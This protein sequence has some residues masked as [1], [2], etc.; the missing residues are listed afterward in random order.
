MGSPALHGILLGMA[1]AL[2]LPSSAFAQAPSGSN[3]PNRCRGFEQ[4]TVSGAESELHVVC[5]QAGTTL[6][7][8]DGFEIADL[9]ALRS[10]V[11]VTTLHGSKRAWLLMQEDE[12]L[13]AVEEITGT[14]ARAMGRGPQRKID[15]LDLDLGRGA[16]GLLTAALKPGAQRPE[17]SSAPSRADIDLA[18]LVARSR[19]VRGA[20]AV[21]GK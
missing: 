19:Q 16:A 1:V 6:G 5:G 10:A 11:V 8:V 13:L 9:P 15:D 17:G 3:S 21:A 18:G 20:D 7:P 12:R 2:T 14:I 4:T